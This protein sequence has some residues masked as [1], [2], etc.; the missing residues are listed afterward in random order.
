MLFVLCYILS[1]SF[2]CTETE[3]KRPERGRRE[4]R[5]KNERTKKNNNKKDEEEEAEE[6]RKIQKGKY[7][8][9]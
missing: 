3:A 5:K 2:L 8:G 9:E 4:K 1:F 6:E 7:V